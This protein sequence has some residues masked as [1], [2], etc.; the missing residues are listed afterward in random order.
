MTITT[1]AAALEFDLADRMRKALR[2]S[3][4]GVGEIAEQLEVSATAVSTWI[5]GRARPR[6][7]DLR[8]FAEITG[9]TVEWLEQG[10]AR[11]ERLEL[12]TFCSVADEVEFWRIIDAA[13]VLA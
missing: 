11:P 13:G 1:N 12:P 6:Q 8:R 4:I 5:N 10:F 2:V 9:V 3:G 7:R